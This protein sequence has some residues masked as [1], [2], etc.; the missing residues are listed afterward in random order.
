MTSKKSIKVA[1]F[2]WLCDRVQMEKHEHWILAETLHRKEFY[3]TV[4][5]DDNRAQDGIQLREDF[6]ADTQTVTYEELIR[7]CSMLEMMIALAERFDDLMPDPKNAREEQARPAKWFWEMTKNAGLY[8]FTDTYYIN[9][10]HRIELDNILN[11]ILAREYDAN[12]VGGLFPLKNAEKNQKK[13]EIWYQMNAYI[14]E[15]TIN[16]YL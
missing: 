7:P 1:Y 15:K 5:N 8:K 3:W 16:S 14:M 12:G 4:P 2:D 13:V 6:A 10:D 11:R 9:R